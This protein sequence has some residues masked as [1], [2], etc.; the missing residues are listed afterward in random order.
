MVKCYLNISGFLCAG[1]TSFQT[2]SATESNIK[3]IVFK[4]GFITGYTIG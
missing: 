4:C 2:M 1:D 3:K